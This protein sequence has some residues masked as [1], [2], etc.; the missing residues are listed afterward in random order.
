MQFLYND[1]QFWHFMQPE[2]FEQF[3]AGETR[4]AMPRSGSRTARSAS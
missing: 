1:G 2:T 3:A 4:S